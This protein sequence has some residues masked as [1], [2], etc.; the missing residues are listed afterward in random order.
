MMRQQRSLLIKA[1]FLGILFNPLSGYADQGLRPL[2]WSCVN[3]ACEPTTDAGRDGDGKVLLGY[4]KES[5]EPGT[6]PLHWVCVAR[7]HLG[8]CR[9]RALVAHPRY[10]D[11]VLLGYIPIEPQ[12]GTR[13]LYWSCMQRDA[14]GECVHP[15]PDNENGIAGDN[16]LLGYVYAGLSKASD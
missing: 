14:A 13:P 10:D 5:A 1:V 4:I 3:N 16:R 15:A 7:I 11:S 9:Y 12:P 8:G 6:A 2:Y